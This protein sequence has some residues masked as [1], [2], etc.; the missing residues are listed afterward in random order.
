MRVKPNSWAQPFTA[1]SIPT[2]LPEYRFPA[3]KEIERGDV[4]VFEYPRDNVYKYVKLSL[5]HI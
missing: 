2:F 3:F 4:V 5:I 1:V